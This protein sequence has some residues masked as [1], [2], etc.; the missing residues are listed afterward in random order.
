MSNTTFSGPVRSENG[1]AIVSKN[2]TTGVISN[3]A[4]HTGTTKDS[5]RYYLEENFERLPAINAYLTGSETKDWGS[6]SDD[7]EL[8]EDV[9]VTGAAL[10]DV[11]V[12]AMG[13]DTVAAQITASVTAADTVT[14]VISNVS[15]SAID[16]ASATL[17]VRV[18]KTGTVSF[19][20]NQNFE[21]SGTNMT[22]AL[23]T[24]NADRA[25]IIVTTAGADQD[26]AILTSHADSGQTAWTGTVWGT[27]N[28]VEWECSLN[29]N[30]IDN[31][32]WWAGLKLTHVPESA[33]DA[34]Q[35]YFTF[36]TDNDNSGTS[37]TDFTKLHFIHSIANTDYISQL[38]ITVA[39]NTT[40]HLRIKID[41][42]R[43]AT[44]FV[45]GIQY[46]VTGTAG[47]TGGTAVTV[48]SSK[49]AALTDDIDL[50][51]SIGIE[52]NAGAAELLDVHYTSISRII[53]E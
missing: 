8:E 14:V 3:R 50:I 36:G 5:N 49:T 32:W 42:D 47:A 15:G 27:E 39:A 17:T 43:K 23:V 10:G 41:S 40:Y 2:A 48:G 20:K 6:I 33:T 31:Q 44:I 7:T 25:G 16:L 24:R 12:A 1:F 4:R 22:T 29:P 21:V 53:Y 30:A 26:Q 51:P 19:S 45:N 11:A 38:P 9:T 52:A 46:N 18:F 34:N 28:Q 35:A 13:V 37:L